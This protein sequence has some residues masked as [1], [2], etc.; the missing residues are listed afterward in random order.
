MA[1][2]ILEELKLPPRPKWYFRAS[3]LIVGFLTV[4]PL[5]LPLVLVNP[6]YSVA[7][8]ITLSMIILAISLFLIKALAGAIK[9]ISEYY[10]LTG[11]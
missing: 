5:I 9:S 2:Q 8:K 10:E 7:K 4:G 11:L 1:E 3:T 6:R